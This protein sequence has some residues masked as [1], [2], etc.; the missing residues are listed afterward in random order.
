MVQVIGIPYDK[1]SSFLKGP[2]LAPAQIRKVAA[3]GASNEYA[4]NGRRIL[5]G[6][7]FVDQGD[8]EVLTLPA[9]QAFQ[10]IREAVSGVLVNDYRLVCLGGDHSVSYPI[11][12]AFSQH[13]DGLS[14]L[15]LDA[16][17]D[18]YENFEDNPYSHA[19]P[20]ARLLETGRIRRVV[21]VG[22]RTLNAHQKEQAERYDVEIIPMA[23]W[24]SNVVERLEGPIYVSLD[25]DVLDP[26]FAPGLSHHEPGGASVRE[27]LDLIQNIKVPIV[28]VDIVEYNPLRDIND[29]TARVAYKLFKELISRM[30]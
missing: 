1:N 14:I 15:H 13:Y 20:F 30:L 17:P 7:A 10:T 27:V 29:M 26:A 2:H 18:L 4:E 28:G 5:P 24:N 8:L 22:I 21:Q 23:E 6:E 16:H 19:S 25:M 3:D 11:I 9:E 12:D